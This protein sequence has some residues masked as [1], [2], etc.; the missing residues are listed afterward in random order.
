MVPDFRQSLSGGSNALQSG[1]GVAQKVTLLVQMT[2]PDSR[3]LTNDA[4]M[5]AWP[6][7]INAYRGVRNVLVRSQKG[8]PPAKDFYAMLYGAD[9]ETL[10]RATQS[11][12]QH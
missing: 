8:G 3:S 2:K 10:Y 7:K 11:L 4:I 12:K 6:E 1:L 9:S 5:Q